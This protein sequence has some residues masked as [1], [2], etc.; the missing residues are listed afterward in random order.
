MNLSSLNKYYFQ[1]FPNI[2]IA[3]RKYSTMNTSKSPPNLLSTNHARKTLILA[4][5]TYE[6][7]GKMRNIPVRGKQR[8]YGF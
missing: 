7:L 5:C 2:V 3:I 4:E 1:L 8:K 6:Q